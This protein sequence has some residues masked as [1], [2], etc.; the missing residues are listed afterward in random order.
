[1]PQEYNQ[2]SEDAHKHQVM[3][4]EIS[5]QRETT[6]KIIIRFIVQFKII[7]T[8]PPVW[9]IKVLLMGHCCLSKL[10]T[11]QSTGSLSSEGN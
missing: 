3:W 1:M 8:M 4:M 11:D 10:Y 6:T 5:G 9:L 7:P 2:Q